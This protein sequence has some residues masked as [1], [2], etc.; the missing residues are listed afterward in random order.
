MVNTELRLE[1]GLWVKKNSQSWVRISHGPK[2]FVMNLNS[3]ET[4]I[5]EVQLEEQALK[6][7]AKDFACRSKANNK[8]AKKRTCWLFTEYIPMKE[9][10]LDWYWTMELPLSL[11]TRF[12]RRRNPSSSDILRKYNEKITER[13]ISGELKNH[14]QG[15]FFHKF[16]IGLT[17]DGKYAWQEEEE[18]REDHQLLH[19]FFKKNR[20]SPSSSMT[21]RTQSY[22]SFITGQC[23][24]SQRILP[25]YLPYW[26]CV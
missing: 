20:L 3:N 13:F 1:F 5:P 9:R 2:R 16:L 7:S 22:W 18:V 6:L 4:E 26:M 19:W 25:S 8:T 10:K 24:D 15:Q 12:R 23:C 11:R 17:I 14:L 21:F